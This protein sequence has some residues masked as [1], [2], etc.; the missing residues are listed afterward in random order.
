MKTAR[1]KEE[2]GTAVAQAR[3]EGKVVGLVPTMG[4]FHDGHLE[5]IRISASRAG[6][7]VVSLFV[8]PTQFAPG[9]DLEHYPRDEERDRNLAAAEGAGLLFAPSV[10]EMYAAGS[11][12]LV[13]ETELSRTLC[14]LSRPGHFR[15][16]TT[17]VAK[18]FNIVQPD[19][20]VFGRKDLQQ[21][22]VIR[23]MARDLAFPVEILD[24]P[25]VREPDGLAMSS[26]NVYLDP[27][28]RERAPGLY[29]SLIKTAGAVAAGDDR[30]DELLSRARES[31]E[32]RTGGRVE[33]LEALDS[34]LAQASAAADCAYLAAA[35]QLGGTRLI[36]N[37]RVPPGAAGDG[38]E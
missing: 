18:L 24:A 1:T 30:L 36:D 4:G 6:F 21:L 38:V 25:V 35:V 27:A 20:A 11:S 15:G 28:Q 32:Q 9:E 13:E 7:T 17:V 12:T 34:G 14:G 37:V 29:A 3:R 2:V 16:V 19:L 33:Y 23:R 22:M 10:D 31:V 8:N 26:R 5:L